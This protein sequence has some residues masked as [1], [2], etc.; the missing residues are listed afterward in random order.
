MAFDDKFLTEMYGKEV[1]YYC[2][3]VVAAT[4]YDS[5]NLTQDYSF[6]NY[7]LA[8]MQNIFPRRI[9]PTEKKMNRYLGTKVLEDKYIC[10]VP[11]GHVSTEREMRE[12]YNV[13]QNS[14][15]WSDCLSKAK[16]CPD[17]HFQDWSGREEVRKM[18]L[19]NRRD[20]AVSFD[21]Q[22]SETLLKDLLLLC[23]DALEKCNYSFDDYQY[24]L[25]F[26]LRMENDYGLSEH[27]IALCRKYG[28]FLWQDDNEDVAMFRKT[29]SARKGP[30]PA[31]YTLDDSIFISFSLTE[32]VQELL[33][34][35]GLY[36]VW[37]IIHS[38]DKNVMETAKNVL[39]YLCFLY[40]DDPLSQQTVEGYLTYI[41]KKI[42]MSEQ[43]AFENGKPKKSFLCKNPMMAA[44]AQLLEMI[45]S[46]F[47]TS[48]ALQFSTCS[49]SSCR[50]VFCKEHGNKK[51]CPMCNSG[52]D[53]VRIHRS[54]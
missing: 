7:S 5:S 43:I 48:P 15:L 6:N 44:K 29:I 37:R 38:N 33:E 26:P 47:L 1:M 51:L 28:M 14:Q 23:D 11:N 49:N 46:S 19:H 52:K 18:Y 21:I 53:R 32:F 45:C 17:M 25:N 4:V 41:S 54:K 34:L 20:V 40:P 42:D 35:Y 30:P 16:C 13:F 10:N 22:Q 39:G 31:T 9:H 27:V 24:P 8:D 50:N 3:A 2:C 12:I 36:L